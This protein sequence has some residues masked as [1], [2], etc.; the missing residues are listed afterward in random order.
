MWKIGRVNGLGRALFARTGRARRRRHSRAWPFISLGFSCVCVRFFFSRG[1]GGFSTFPLCYIIVFK[2]C[3][4]VRA[5]TGPP[6]H[7]RRNNAIHACGRLM[8]I[9]RHCSS[10]PERRRTLRAVRKYRTYSNAS[11]YR[12]RVRPH[13]EREFLLYSA[14]VD[15]PVAC[16][17]LANSFNNYVP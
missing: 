11:E 9:G 1:G 10:V 16:T 14:T 8:E 17:Y 12:R 13:T 3:C 6:P 4:T 2:T 15:W 7:T 5:S